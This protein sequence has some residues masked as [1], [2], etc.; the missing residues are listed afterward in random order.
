MR[1]AFMST[2][3]VNKPHS[4]SDK[5]E[6]IARGPVFHFARFRLADRFSLGQARDGGLSGS[7]RQ[8]PVASRKQSGPVRK[9]AWR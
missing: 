1:F 9:S 4:S 8:R 2:D 5:Q 7:R 3:D 6:L